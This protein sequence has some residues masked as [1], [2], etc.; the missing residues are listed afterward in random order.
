MTYVEV[1]VLGELIVPHTLSSGIDKRGR[2]H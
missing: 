1:L 2:Q